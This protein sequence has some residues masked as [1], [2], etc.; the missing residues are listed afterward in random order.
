MI[1]FP[2]YIEL[3]ITNECNLTCSNCNRFNNYNFRGHYVWEANRTAL[4][5]WSRRVTA[6]M[7][8]IIGGE[9][10]L[11][12]ELELWTRGAATFWPQSRV[13]IQTN[14]LIPLTQLTWWHRALID[15]PNI[16]TGVAIHDQRFKK[17]FAATWGADNQHGQFDAT[18][19]SQCAL[20]AQGVSF[21][22]HDSDPGSAWRAC[23]MKHS[24]TI[25]AGRLYR[26]PMVAVLPEF[27]KQYKVTLTAKQQQLLDS[28][29][30][31]AADCSDQDLTDFLA[32]RHTPMPQCA[33]CPSQYVES[34]VTFD[35]SRKKWPPRL[36][37]A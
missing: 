2:T 29:R 34:T 18:K 22:V 37:G 19:F 5:A 16:G 31:L 35:S 6:P 3:Y 10:T 32:Q 9:P 30:S 26:C 14:G 23:S 4:E 17:K 21:T 11:H 7:I 13:V 33:L 1:A 8:T 28:Y 25:L 36:P 27:Q 24:H 12:P 20:Q 15:H